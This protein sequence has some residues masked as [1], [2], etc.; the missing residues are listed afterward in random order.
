MSGTSQ[1]PKYYIYIYIYIYI[2]NLFFI[3]GCAG[4]LLL[5][6]LSS[7]CSKW[8]ILSSCRSQASHC[9]GF[10]CCGALAPGHIGHTDL[11]VAARGL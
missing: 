10:A 7:S 5:C 6:G 4:S 8:E 9:S 3:S 11:A 2:K 1:G